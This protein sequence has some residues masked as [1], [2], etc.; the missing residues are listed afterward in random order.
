MKKEYP[1]TGKIANIWWYLRQKDKIIEIEHPYKGKVISA[2][3][4]DDKVRNMTIIKEYSPNGKIQGL[5]SNNIRRFSGYKYNQYGYVPD[6]Y[7]IAK[8]I[9]YLNNK[10]KIYIDP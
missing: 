4:I 8:R 2:T 3:K 7:G 9:Y 10:E 1:N 5:S 6:R